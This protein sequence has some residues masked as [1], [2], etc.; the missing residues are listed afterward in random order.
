M[1]YAP[2]TYEAIF[3]YYK[4]RFY[5]IIYINFIH[6]Y[7]IEKIVVYYLTM[8]FSHNYKIFNFMEYK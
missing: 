1:D 6:L 2:Y 5:I 8:L 4:A 3:N 7:R